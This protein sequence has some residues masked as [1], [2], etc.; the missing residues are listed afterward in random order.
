[1]RERSLG[2]S[3]RTEYATSGN[4]AE[5]RAENI[6]THIH[7]W[8]FLI[9]KG[10]SMKLG[11]VPRQTAYLASQYN[12][13]LQR[14]PGAPGVGNGLQ[15]RLS[16]QPSRTVIDTVLSPLRPEQP[17]RNAGAA[18]GGIEWQYCYRSA[19]PPTALST[20]HLM[21][22]RAATQSLRRS[23]RCAS[24]R[25]LIRVLQPRW[26]WIVGASKERLLRQPAGAPV[27]LAA[28]ETMCGR[29]AGARH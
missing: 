8:S 28:L 12:H 23:S 7:K 15:H 4:S 2:H 5:K 29:G 17:E 24:T 3:C 9:V 27:G 18:L 10:R 11:I 22:R 6:Q 14:P 16:I 1:M 26:S 13:L 25:S 20:A 21:T 19:A